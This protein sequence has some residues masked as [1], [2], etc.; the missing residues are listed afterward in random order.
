VSVPHIDGEK[1]SMWQIMKIL[2]LSTEK[3][4]LAHNRLTGYKVRK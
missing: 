3:Y 2:N 4:A 1:S